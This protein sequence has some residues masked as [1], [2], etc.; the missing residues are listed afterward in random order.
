MS[1][2]DYR[3]R[4][5]I[6][7]KDDR[8]RVD[9][10]GSPWDAIGQVNVGGYRRLGLCT[11]TLV[12]PDLF[13][14]AAHCV[15]GAPLHRIHFLAGVRGSEYKEHATAK[16]LRF[17]EPDPHSRVAPPIEAYTTDAAVIELSAKLSVK[18][19]ELAEGV[20]LR[21]GL[22][23]VHA[24]YS[25]DRRYAVSAHFGCRPT[26]VS[27][28]GLLYTTCDTHPA[29]S[30][31]PIFVDDND[32]LKVAAILI[33]GFKGGANVGLSISEWLPLIK[34]SSCREE[35]SEQRVR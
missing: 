28:T 23:L 19:A 14:T 3:L 22:D 2:Q 1:G 6:I 35:P 26:F 24:A 10:K 32:K 12:A 4:P 20:E 16:C 11:G 30:G 34:Q 17:I 9:K 5:G 13:L 33:A 21:L 25:A 18:P 15:E 29:S 8:V 31:G 7:G 27:D